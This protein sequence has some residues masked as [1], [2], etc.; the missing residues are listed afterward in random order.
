L[1]IKFC[2]RTNWKHSLLPICGK[3]TRA[4]LAHQIFF[5]FSWCV[6]K[7]I[8]VQKLFQTQDGGLN[9]KY[10]YLILIYNFKD[11]LISLSIFHKHHLGNWLACQSIS[12]SNLGLASGHNQCVQI[13]VG[14]QRNSKQKPKTKW[15]ITK[16]QASGGSADAH[17]ASQKN[18]IK[19]Q[20]GKHE[21]KF[22]F[23]I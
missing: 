3:F 13:G 6:I 5:A 14:R 8:V 20:I 12:H 18:L 1:L 17:I 11:S 23:S 9:F 4:L 15:K 22:S 19:W 7:K 21:I 16:L 10:M 2:C